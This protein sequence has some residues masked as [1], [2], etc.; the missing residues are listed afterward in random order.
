MLSPTRIKMLKMTHLK[1]LI[2]K[3]FITAAS[4]ALMTSAA[5]A[6]DNTAANHG[7]NTYVKTAELHVEAPK[8]P[9]SKAMK[10]APKTTSKRRI[11]REALPSH[12]Q[13]VRTVDM[14]RIF[15]TRDH[16]YDAMTIYK[17]K[18]KTQAADMPN[19]F[20]PST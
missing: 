17:P 16:A 6:Q 5:S 4:A 14:G 1:T 2:V 10:A 18:T 11:V 13:S 3:T 8:A 20:K 19:L 7:T 9:S 15:T 12:R